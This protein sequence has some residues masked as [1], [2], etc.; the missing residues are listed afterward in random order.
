[1]RMQEENFEI[2]LV[3]KFYLLTSAFYETYTF[4]I[5]VKYHKSKIKLSSYAKEVPTGRGDIVLLIPNL[6]TRRV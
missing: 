3:S 2:G 5:V 4:D 6:G 1:M